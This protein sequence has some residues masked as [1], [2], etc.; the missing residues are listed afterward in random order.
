MDHATV[1]EATLTTTEME[2]PTRHGLAAANILF[3]LGWVALVAGSVRRAAEG[4]ALT[5]GG[6]LII[7]AGAL[8]AVNVGGAGL[9]SLHTYE[10]WARRWLRRDV[11]LA[12]DWY[13]FFGGVAM[14]IGVVALISG[15]RALR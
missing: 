3:F 14:A 1:P 8:I 7:V 15:L 4:L 12:A 6:V 13:R 9:G 5:I 10:A 2:K 11:T